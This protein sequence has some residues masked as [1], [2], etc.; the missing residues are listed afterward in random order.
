MSNIFKKK[1]ISSATV[2][3]ENSNSSSNSFS[4]TSNTSSSSG[5]SWNTSNVSKKTTNA[6]KAAEKPFSSQYTDY[7]NSAINKINSRADFSYDLNEDALYQQY[8]EQYKNLGNQAMTD[9]M[10]NAASL[11]GGYGSSYATTAGQQAYNN[12]LQQLNDIVPDL[13]SQARSNY[14]TETEN[15]YNEANLYAGLESEDYSK[16][17]D[18]RSY[19]SDKYNN[20]WNQNAVSHSSQI[21]KSTQTERSSSSSSS[22]GSSTSTSY[23]P[24]TSDL[25]LPSAQEVTN[26]SQNYNAAMALLATYGIDADIKKKN[27]YTGTA[28]YKNYLADALYEA[29]NTA[30]TKKSRKKSSNTKGSE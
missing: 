24:K 21:D 17:S 27:E 20:E 28:K 26:A 10:A 3:N 6:L 2:S 18:N 7:L 9:T 16:W 12:Y 8:A 22:S 23:S 15:L 1:N 13:Y 25:A 11:T 4:S 19:Y 5:K 29:I 30:Y 14:D